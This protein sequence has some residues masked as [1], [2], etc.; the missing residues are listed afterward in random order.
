MSIFQHPATAALCAVRPTPLDP[1]AAWLAA[2]Q[3]R[4]AGT[5]EGAV[6]QLLGQH[7]PCHVVQ[8][9]PVAP[10][11]THA[12]RLY[13]GLWYDLHETT[14]GVWWVHVVSLGWFQ[15]RPAVEHPFLTA[16]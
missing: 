1:A 4:L 12:R 16:C 10:N 13:S 9:W 15:A 7:W 11:L 3:T 8:A 2:I 5:R 14:F 6:E